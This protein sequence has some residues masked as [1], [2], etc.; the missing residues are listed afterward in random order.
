[1]TY[2]VFKLRK[3][4][5]NSLLQSSE[6]TGYHGGP[7]FRQIEYDI[8]PKPL[9]EIGEFQIALHLYSQGQPKG[10]S[11]LSYHGAR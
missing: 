2:G 7:I 11:G 10:R 5:L 3:L 9:V 4:I 6:L 8:V 1:M